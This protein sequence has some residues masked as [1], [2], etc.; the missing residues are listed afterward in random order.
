MLVAGILLIFSFGFYIYPF[1]FKTFP[2]IDIRIRS[3]IVILISISISIAAVALQKSIEKKGEKNEFL[4]ID[5]RN[6][7]Y[8]QKKQLVSL[9]EYI[10]K[11]IAQNDN[12]NNA[13]L[14]ATI[15]ELSNAKVDDKTYEKFEKYFKSII[16]KIEQQ[17]SVADEKSSI[18]LNRG[19]LYA[20]F[21]ITFFIFSIAAW[22][23]LSLI[24]QFHEH[25]IYGII[26]C[27]ILFIFVEFISAWFLKQYRCFIDTSTYLIKIKSIFDKYF[28]CYMFTK[29]TK[30]SN[31]HIQCM[32]DILSAEIKWPES[33]L[34]KKMDNGFA[35]EAMES[36]TC[37]FEAMKSQTKEL[38]TKKAENDN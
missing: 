36:M 32:L 22:Q 15:N 24:F 11:L 4:E 6:S 5:F 25:F 16:D 3:I 23:I 9:Q 19:I 1:V 14:I 30:T 18:L 8:N 10:K 17:I 13:E 34:S 2:E 20:K 38:K 35:K 27:S 26:S 28:L 31:Q 37:F 29:E 33:Y 7:P 12:K 21:G